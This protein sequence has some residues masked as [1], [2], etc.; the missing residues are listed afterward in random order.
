MMEG[1]SGG[2]TV[3][4]PQPLIVSG[5]VS[6]YP[7]RKAVICELAMRLFANTNFTNT[8]NVQQ[9]AKDALVR[10]EIFADTAGSLIDELIP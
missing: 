6:N 7:T 10:A 4:I 8:S 1:Q 5:G 9:A 3:E 2:G